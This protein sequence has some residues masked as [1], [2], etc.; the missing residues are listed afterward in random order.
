MRN[1]PALKKIPV[2]V[3]C[4]MSINQSLLAKMIESGC[5]EVRT[6]PLSQGQLHGLHCKYLAISRRR[7]PR[8]SVH[9]EVIV[10]GDPPS[11]GSF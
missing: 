5:T 1:D 9:I 4:K 7:M 6:A 2:F 8:V 11:A 10:E 3:I